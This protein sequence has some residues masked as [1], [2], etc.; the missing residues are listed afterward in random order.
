MRMRLV[1]HGWRGRPPRPQDAAFGWVSPAR[2]PNS[3]AIPKGLK[4]MASGLSNLRRCEAR[5]PVVTTTRTPA[6]SWS[7]RTSSSIEAP[8]I[9]G[10]S[11]SSKSTSGGLALAAASPASPLP[12][13]STT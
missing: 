11:R 9:P 8:S 4:R 13:S 12:A 7:F 1:Y 5:I 6:K 3:S 10:K 2:T